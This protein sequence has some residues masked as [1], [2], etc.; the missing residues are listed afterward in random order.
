M[1]SRLVVTPPVRYAFDR[2]SV[3]STDCGRARRSASGLVCATFYNGQVSDVA[4]TAR[5]VGV[6]VVLR[7][8][9]IRADWR[10]GSA[11]VS[12][13]ERADDAR[14]QAPDRR[15]DFFMHTSHLVLTF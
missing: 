2:Y 11:T 4:S 3:L 10:I 13:D 6:R 5:L 12:T 1:G 9:A 7:T 14:R 8:G 15:R